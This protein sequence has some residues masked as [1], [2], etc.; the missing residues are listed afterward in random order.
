MSAPGI[1][2]KRRADWLDSLTPLAAVESRD[3]AQPRGRV[4]A[5]TGMNPERAAQKLARILAAEDLQATTPVASAARSIPSAQQIAKPYDPYAPGGEQGPI[6]VRTPQPDGETPPNAVAPTPAPPRRQPSETDTPANSAP[7]STGPTVFEQL[8]D[9]DSTAGTPGTQ[10]A[11]FIPTP[12]ATPPRQPQISQTPASRTDDLLVQHAANPEDPGTASTAA[13]PDLV[14]N[15]RTIFLT[16][17]A[18]TEQDLAADADLVRQ[19]PM[20]G[21]YIGNGL[22]AYDRA[23]MRIDKARYTPIEQ[24]YD[25]QW[26]MRGTYTVEEMLR[27]QQAMLRLQAAGISWL[28][29]AV[30]E[31]VNA[32]KDLPVLLDPTQPPKYAPPAT[33]PV[34]SAPAPSRPFNINQWQADISNSVYGAVDDMFV[35]PAVVLWEYKRGEGGHSAA[36]AARAAAELGFNIVTTIPG[37]DTAIA[38]G[39]A[40]FLRG[41]RRLGPEARALIEGADSAADAARVSNQLQ[42]QRLVDEVDEFVGRQQSG[43]G[44]PSVAPPSRGD[45]PNPVLPVPSKP[46]AGSAGPRQPRVPDP[47][48]G[49]AGIPGDL[50]PPNPRAV[51]PQLQHAPGRWV[52]NFARNGFESVRQLPRRL[53]S[54]AD[55]L[56]ATTALVLQEIAAVFVRNPLLAGGPNRLPAPGRFGATRFNMEAP[57]GNNSRVQGGG[58]GPEQRAA[59]G[60]PDYFK[61]DGKPVVRVE[62]SDP[63]LLQP[64][65]ERNIE[66]AKY[67][68]DERGV[69]HKVGT[70]GD[71]DDAQAALPF[72]NQQLKQSGEYY[73]GSG[74]GSRYYFQADPDTTSSLGIP[75]AV[76]ADTVTGTT[77]DM[78]RVTWRDGKIVSVRSVDATGTRSRRPRAYISA[79]DTI[80][81]KLSFAR[82][83]QA[84]EVVYVAPSDDY[85]NKVAEAFVDNP[86]VRIVNPLTGFDRVGG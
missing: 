61:P 4:H 26:A 15:P 74:S 11:P 53:L 63:R 33:E 62:L 60:H 45:L 44:G 86:K 21:P 13:L 38:A 48:P 1:D 82:K 54:K 42:A 78:I 83:H 59:D 27:Q 81:N 24:L 12:D 58:R 31:H 65:K 10:M 28:D 9:P 17:T 70:K 64:L 25:L 68:V 51:L 20:L 3:S 52:P 75:K 18:Y 32:V 49:N 30:R 29:P 7:A 69:P 16:G 84:Q 23:W 34:D 39:G 73:S 2:W 19:G 80:N 14:A 66:G 41:I 8:Y 55:D 85:A 67:F 46:P 72:L 40:W 57:R 22:S 71:N 76:I 77:A 47:T 50:R 79:I 43:F 37:P 6:P 35:N 56:A 5:Y 36:E